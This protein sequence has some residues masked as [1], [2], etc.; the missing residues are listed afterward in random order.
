[1]KKQKLLLT[2]CL[3]LGHGML[4]Q[5]QGRFIHSIGCSFLADYMAAPA[6]VFTKDETV[7]PYEEFIDQY[8]GITIFTLIYNCRFNVVEL[9]DELALSANAIPGIGMFVPF[10][11]DAKGWGSVNIPLMVGF[12]TGAGSTYASTA[13]LGAFIRY[14][15]EWTKAPLIVTADEYSEVKLESSWVQPVVQAGMRFWNKQNRLQELSIKYGFGAKVPEGDYSLNSDEP[16]RAMSIR[17]SW[18][19]FVNY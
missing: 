2:F 14:G 5:E 11:G 6:T 8:Q 19:M 4:A 18:L 13:G 10:N 9:T 15:I 16:H 1:M 17:I 12:E 7:G 3:L